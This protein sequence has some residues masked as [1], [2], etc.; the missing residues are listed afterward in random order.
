MK[1]LF[2]FGFGYTAAALGGAL[3]DRDWRVHYHRTVIASGIPS[4]VLIAE[5]VK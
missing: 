2:C 1:L 3:P 5:A 4:E